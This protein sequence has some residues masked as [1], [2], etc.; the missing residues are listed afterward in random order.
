MSVISPDEA[1]LKA[2]AKYKP[3]AYKMT[4]QL[5]NHREDEEQPEVRGGGCL[6]QAVG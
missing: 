1:N 6:S 5:R 3:M 2:E 4:N